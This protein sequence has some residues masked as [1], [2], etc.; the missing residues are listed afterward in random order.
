M[1]TPKRSRNMRSVLALGTNQ[2][3]G[4]LEKAQ[5]CDFDLECLENAQEFITTCI[6]FL[7]HE[8]TV[9]DEKMA[10]EQGYAP[11]TTKFSIH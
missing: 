10:L 2:A 6:Q 3:I 11:L 1:N 4:W 9:A 5:E 7:R 8:K